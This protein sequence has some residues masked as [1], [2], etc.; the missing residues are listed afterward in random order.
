MDKKFT[1]SAERHG[2]IARDLY[3]LRATI[4]MPE[5]VLNE[6]WEIIGYSPNFLHLTNSIF[7]FCDKRKKFKYFLKEGDF[8]RIEGYIKKVKALENLPYDKGKKWQLKYKGP[9]ASDKIGE[10]WI[11]NR[12]IKQNRWAIKKVDGTM[13]IIHD[14][15]F[16][17]PVDRYLMYKY[18]LEGA[19]EDT[20]INYKIKTSSIKENIR[21]LSVVI[22][23][24]SGDASKYPDSFGYTGCTGSFNNSVAKLQRLGANVT[25]IQEVLEPDTEYFIIYERTGGRI[26][27]ILRNLKTG[28]EQPPI[29]M[30][31]SN[32]IYDIYNHFGFTTY[33]GDLEVYDVEAFTRKSILSIEQFKIPFDFEVRLK[34]EKIEEKVFKLRIGQDA[35]DGKT[36]IKLLFEDITEKKRIN[37]ELEES[38]KKLRDLALHLQIIREDERSQIARE[39]HDELGQALSA[40]KLDM[41]TLKKRLPQNQEPLIEKADSMS[42]LIDN[43]SL[44]LQ[45]ITANLR[46][47]LLDDLGL[48]PA[49]EWQLEEF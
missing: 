48:T 22:S 43:T 46:P 25:T 44:A 31:D 27:R 12:G 34:D 30:I 33:S 7:D 39:I 36:R 40:L 20:K 18:D 5:V 37:V 11:S 49:I 8:D 32:A 29:E 26:T 21:D 47:R 13:K 10:T 15:D 4:N 23:G 6:N 35:V 9:T 41:Y 16:E 28:L 42:N 24:I 19:D 1:G 45:R 14:A 38:Y 17:N 3:S 2:E